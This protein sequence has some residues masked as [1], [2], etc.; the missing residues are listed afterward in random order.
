MIEQSFTLRNDSGLHARPAAL[1]VQAVQR[2]PGT[3]V[4]VRSGGREVNAR[5]LLSVLSL[6][7]GAGSTISVRCSGPQESDVLGAL[8]A[9]V[10]DGFGEAG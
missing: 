8:S 4:F 10:S 9:L 3:D 5:S 1:F 2:F 6:G 7:A